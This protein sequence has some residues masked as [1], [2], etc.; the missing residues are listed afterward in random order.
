MIIP[1]TVMRQWLP[2][3]LLLALGPICGGA[4]KGERLYVN[5]K[6]A[7]EN[8]KDLQKIQEAVRS[9]YPA[10]KDATIGI[11]IGEATGS[12]VIVNDSGLVLTA[13]HVAIG[14]GKEV[15][16]VLADG[17]ELKAKTLGLNS[18]TDAG[19]AQIISSEDRNFPY[20][21]IDDGH[22][23]RLGDWVLALGHSGGVDPERGAVVR[24][25]RLVRMAAKTIQSDCKLIGGDSGGPL[26]DLN[27]KLIGIN[28]R[29]GASLEQN[30]HVPVSE[31]HDHWDTLMAGEFIGEGPFAEKPEPGQAFIGIGLESAD[32]GGVLVTDVG[33]ET[34]AEDA[35]LR[36]GDLL[37]SWNGKAVADKEELLGLIEE[38]F[39]GDQVKLGIVRDGGEET[40][41]LELGK[42]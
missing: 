16:V 27:G 21:E 30:M 2:M 6:K 22:G 29:V 37:Q 31:F 18:E 24:L 26:F 14:V 13:A 7:P 17:T 20:V 12:G 10:L 23:A 3:V 4:V 34:P 38:A 33:E 5:D 19:M 1:T 11:R 35:G 32:E 25:G 40:I 15:T 41:N 36:S 42:R 28:S 39:P 9:V 8:L